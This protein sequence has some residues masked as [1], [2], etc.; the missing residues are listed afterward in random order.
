MDIYCIAL[1][2]GAI[3]GVNW[4]YR[5]EDRDAALGKTG[6]RIEVEFSMTVPDGS[7]HDEIDSLADDF[8]WNKLY[9]GRPDTSIRRIKKR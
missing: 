1:E 2:G 4:Y 6:A 3:G 8:Y 5:K 9:L 7:E